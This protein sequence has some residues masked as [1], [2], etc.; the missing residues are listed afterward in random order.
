MVEE[1]PSEARP[2]K[3][4]AIL[5][6]LMEDVRALNSA[7]SLLSQKMRNLA[8][9]E[10][11]LGRNLIVL[12]KKVRELSEMGSAQALPASFAEKIS[13]LEKRLDDTNK[14]LEE[15]NIIVSHLRKEF[16]TYD[17]FKELKQIVDAINPLELATIDQVK[18]LIGRSHKKDEEL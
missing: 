7:I 2:L 17:D 15:L 8:R 13:A 18:E 6:Q 14:K 4:S 3:T 5:M 11:I 16:V 9:N 10:K 1:G 12:N